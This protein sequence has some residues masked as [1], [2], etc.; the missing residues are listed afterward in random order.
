M[1]KKE[2]IKKIQQQI[3]KNMGNKVRIIALE[4]KK[5][6]DEEGVIFGVYSRYFIVR[7]NKLNRSSLIN[8]SFHYTDVLSKSVTVTL[9]KNSDE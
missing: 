3:E 4:G 1:I 8:M 2:D 7:I 9:L 6:I 5:K